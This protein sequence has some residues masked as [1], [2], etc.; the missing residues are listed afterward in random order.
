M[1]EERH[2]KQQWLLQS[3]SLQGEQ[4][5]GLLCSILEICEKAPQKTFGYQKNLKRLNYA[6][7]LLQRGKKQEER[8]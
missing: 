4:Q 3:V 5:G 6:E 7:K 2:L 1:L 8:T